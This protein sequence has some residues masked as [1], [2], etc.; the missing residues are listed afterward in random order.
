M[1]KG[2]GA[3]AV[4]LVAGAAWLWLGSSGV[5]APV[6]L[7]PA[8]PP[9]PPRVVGPWSPPA[10]PAEL[11]LVVAVTENGKGVAGATVNVNRDGAPLGT[12]TTDALGHATFRFT[13]G[14]IEVAAEAHGATAFRAATLSPLHAD[15]RVDIALEVR[16]RVDVTVIDGSS[17]E[18][19]E[20][21][22]IEVQASCVPPHLTLASARTDAKGHAAIEGLPP[23]RWMVSLSHPGHV[24]FR[25]GYLS[26]P[27]SP[28]YQL[29]RLSPLRARVV[30][31]D[32][33]PAPG[34]EVSDLDL[35][36]V[37]PERVVADGEGMFTLP[38]AQYPQLCARLGEL[39]GT[40]S[41]T[42]AL[43]AGVIIGRE[44]RVFTG[45]VLRDEDS[46]PLD[47]V[48]VRRNTG[49]LHD[50]TVT[51]DGGTFALPML[52]RDDPFVSFELDGR[53]V[54]SEGLSLDEPNV[55][56]LSSPGALRG[57]VVDDE[58]QAV[59]NARVE[60]D[61]PGEATLSDGDGRFGFER[62][63]RHAELTVSEGER[64]ARLDVEVNAGELVEVTVS[65]GPVLARVPLEVLTDN[66]L[67]GGVWNVSAKRIDGRPFSKATHWHAKGRVSDVLYA[68]ELLL[69]AGS[70]RI[71]AKN[72]SGEGAAEVRI[73]VRAAPQP[74]VRVHATRYPPPP[75]KPKR[76]LAVK[77]VD[78]SGAPVADAGVSCIAPEWGYTRT[79]ADGRGACQLPL[80]S[81]LPMLVKTQVGGAVADAKPQDWSSEVV[82]TLH[83][84][85][86]IRGV[87]L[88]DA[89]TSPS[90]QVCSKEQLELVAFTPPEFV[91]PGQA[92]VRT[93][94][95][96]HAGETKLG[97]AVVLP[98]PDG[99][100]QTTIPLGAPG[101]ARFKV[102]VRG[103]PVASPVLYVDRM[104]T[105]AP[106]EGGV[107]VLT[108]V[109]GQHVLVVNVSDGPERYE[110]VITVEAGRAAD[111]GRI[112]LQ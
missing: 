54:E 97:C 3:L 81:P 87:V 22:L 18:A 73:D 14:P 63:K 109:P 36:W 79:G 98:V 8:P 30:H 46:T 16:A 77:V 49:G 6:A 5:D 40:A 102:Y 65:L 62:V 17:G 38:N 42:E 57:R 86:T 32:G 2:L 89:G 35:G 75:P 45:V 4:L 93:I 12:A 13:P 85:M 15:T 95:C 19:L 78:S 83:G 61:E 37:T 41:L 108:L 20:H 66:V 67:A 26:A 60:L 7:P 74:A 25:C 107:V 39:S 51:A 72:E 68:R 82:L 69:P 43:D 59:A 50:E 53:V 88:G 31:E 106:M 70:F 64:G 71:E 1:K 11:P 90:L 99:E 84:A 105:R 94:L 96:V 24:P 48:R 103:Q 9:P 34:A 58:G 33:R 110:A 111:L 28:V 47:G 55:I 100:V 52:C 80:D 56:R 23:N 21:V 112:D 91:L 27:S 29:S 104:S 44:D 76:A 92:S 101:S 10:V